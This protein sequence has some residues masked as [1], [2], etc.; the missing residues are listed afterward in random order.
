[1]KKKDKVR[2]HCH[3]NGKYREAAHNICNLRYKIP[4]ENPVVFYNGSTY[5]YQFIIK[6]LAKEFES[7]FECLGK[8]TEKYITFSVPIKNEFDNG[9]NI[10]YK[11]KFIDSFRVMSSSLSSLADSLSEGLHNRN[12][13]KCKP[14][15]KIM[16]NY[17]KNKESLCIQ[18][19]EANNLYGW[20]ISE[21]LPVNGFEWV[22]DI[23]RLRKK[24]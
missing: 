19:L 22:K 2:E 7:Q 3:Y 9:Q 10:T 17:D 21:K 16:I 14:C 18:Y 1:M 15:D 24:L 12:C 6:G 5:D 20:V 13:R 11:L 8:N 4:K 23:S